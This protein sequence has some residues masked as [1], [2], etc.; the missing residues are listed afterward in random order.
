[1]SAEQQIPSSGVSSMRWR[2]VTSHI[3]L[4]SLLF[5][6][7]TVAGAASA[8]AKE[9]AP[10]TAPPAKS[11]KP[12]TL[13]QILDNLTKSDVDHEGLHRSNLAIDQLIKKADDLMRKA[14]KER[15][16]DLS[17]KT[18]QSPGTRVLGQVI[19]ALTDA[20]AFLQKLKDLQNALV[21]VRAPAA[22]PKVDAHQTYK[23]LNLQFAA[24]LTDLKN[25]KLGVK[26]LS[27]TQRAI[28]DVIAWDVESRL[29]SAI[30]RIRLRTIQIG[31]ALNL[32][33]ELD[34]EPAKNR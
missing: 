6:L 23:D 27:F 32:N 8:P 14:A 25:L 30:E 31:A 10:Q 13:D 2:R 15:D 16:K 1:M 18:S 29:Y 28:A 26:S 7:A 34:L 12:P 4:L 21:A 17:G 3:T 5:A 9:P 19:L 22:A 11:Q 20:T 24:V 33:S